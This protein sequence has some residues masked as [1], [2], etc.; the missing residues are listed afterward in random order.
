[1]TAGEEGF[2]LLSSKL[3]N[4]ERKPLTIPQLRELGHR[5]QQMERPG[6]DRELTVSDLRRLGYG[7]NQAVHIV[8]LLQDRPILS[9][10][11][12]TGKKQGCEPIT[13]IS[14]AFPQQLRENLGME[15]PGSLWMKGNADLLKTPCVAL[16]GSRELRKENR[17]FAETVGRE[18]A[19]QGY[20]LVSGNAKGADRAA[21]DACLAAGGNVI[22]FIADCLMDK[23]YD[24][25][26]LYISE[27]G[28]DE[29]FTP[30]RALSRNHLIHSMGRFTFVAQSNLETGGSWDGTVYNL[31][32]GCS[33]VFCFRDGSDAMNALADRGAALISQSE[34][35]NFETLQSQEI[36]FF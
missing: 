34:L 14:S 31:R 20:T 35:Q 24:A 22:S 12:Q 10:Y 19:R 16:V 18:A 25:H 17:L 29:P 15:C 5:V 2:L 36:S 23:S 26:I 1:M 13:R 3:G 4:P 6:G 28:F 11:M 27:E 32:K 9:W 7:E 8:D 30:W 33:P 21:Q